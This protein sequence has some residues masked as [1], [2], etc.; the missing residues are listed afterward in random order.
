MLNYEKLKYIKDAQNKLEL[1]RIFKTSGK[2][3]E[4]IIDLWKSCTS[5][6]V[7]NR[8][9]FERFLSRLTRLEQSKLKN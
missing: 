8:K 2:E 4:I 3:D 5:K 7:T 9:D 1:A 6:G